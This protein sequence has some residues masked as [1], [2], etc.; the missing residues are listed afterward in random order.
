MRDDHGLEDVV[1]RLHREIDDELGFVR[2]VE[3][4]IDVDRLQVA[5]PAGGERGCHGFV[6]QRRGGVAS[7]VWV[8]RWIE[9][10]PGLRHAVR[11]DRDDP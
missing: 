10:F 1:S 4:A 6:G 3:D 8:E 11:D 5:V 2:D 7:S 9:I